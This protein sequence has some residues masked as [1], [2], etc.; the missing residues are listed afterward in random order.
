MKN[1]LIAAALA[2]TAFAAPASAITLT[3][4]DMGAYTDIGAGYN[5]FD[6][7]N[8]YTLDTTQYQPSG[9]VNDVISANNIVYNAFGS[10]A[11]ISAAT[12]FEM[13]SAWLAGAWN[14]GLTVRVTG[15]LD[16]ALQY[17]QD[18]TVNT[19]GPS[20][21][22]FNHASVN[23][24]VFSSFGG[25]SGPYEGGGNHFAM[26]NLTLNGGGAVPEPASWA[27]IVAGFGMIGGAMRRRSNVVL[28]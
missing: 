27:L 9:Y 23:N 8:F 19:S 3:F 1:I 16:S 5:G 6:F 4:D 10:D 15:Y 22:T 2:V 26:D 17:S 14:D 21:V 24:V 28:A 18:F 13:T 12:P 7:N 20:L 25:Q 11:S